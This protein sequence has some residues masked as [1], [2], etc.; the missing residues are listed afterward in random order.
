MLLYVPHAYH[1][2]M[3]QIDSFQVYLCKYTHHMYTGI[4]GDIGTVAITDWQVHG[5]NGVLTLIDAF[6]T[7]RRVRKRHVWLP[8]TLGAIYLIWSVIHYAT[9]LTNADGSRYIYRFIRNHLQTYTYDKYA[10]GVR[11][12]LE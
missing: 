3:L 1:H 4:T 11:Q 2:E 12:V 7:S 8:M 9:G 10:T 5:L 6:V